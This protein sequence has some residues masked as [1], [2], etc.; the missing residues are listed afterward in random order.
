MKKYRLKKDLPTFKAGDV[1]TLSDKG[2][3][4]DEGEQAPI[5]A[6]ASQTL[7]KFPNILTDWFEEIPEEPKTVWDLEGDN[8]CWVILYDSVAHYRWSELRFAVGRRA[9][10]GVFL[11]R[12]EAEQELARRKV[13]QILL[14]DT[15]GFKPDWHDGNNKYEVYYDYGDNKLTLR[16]YGFSCSHLDLWF[17]SREDAKTSIK[18][19]EKEWK[20]YLGVEDA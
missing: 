14:R 4:K 20:I 6:Y 15:K 5:L 11:T 18:V 3:W 9:Q 17:A 8:Y 7:K 1:F 2:L 10:G 16:C 12:K 13:R 19:H